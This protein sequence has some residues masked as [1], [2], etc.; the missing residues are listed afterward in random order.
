MVTF[1]FYLIITPPK[2]REN[3]Q[4]TG[5]KNS[6]SGGQDQASDET[7][8]RRKS[9]YKPIIL[10]YVSGNLTHKVHQQPPFIGYSFVLA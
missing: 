1:D 7:V 6:T 9:K 3:R 5:A 2:I 4:K 10:C 8:P